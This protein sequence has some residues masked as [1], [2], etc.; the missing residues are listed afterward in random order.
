MLPLLP[1]VPAAAAPGVEPGPAELA[2]RYQA[3][4]RLRAKRACTIRGYAIKKDVVL[5]VAAVHTN[6][7]G[8]VDAVDLSFSGMV[9]A[10]VD[11][12]TV[13]EH[14]STA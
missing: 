7:Q 4:M 3:G 13:S 10:D 9:I 14:F 12:D 1:A 6:A 2:A 11:V 8:Q 5:T